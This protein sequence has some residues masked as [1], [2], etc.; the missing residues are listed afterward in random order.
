MT[1]PAA[2]ALIVGSPPTSLKAAAFCGG[3]ADAATATTLLA[4][5]AA[6]IKMS[7]DDADRRSLRLLLGFIVGVSPSPIYPEYPLS[8]QAKRTG[9]PYTE[10]QGGFNALVV[11][12]RI[13]LPANVLV[14]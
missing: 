12:R 4:T 9:A 1:A 10:L 11:E 2:P 5:R 3:D 14:E 8:T 7:A 6:S 13:R